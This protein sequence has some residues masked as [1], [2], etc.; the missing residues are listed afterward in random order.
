MIKQSK[1]YAKQCFWFTSLV[2]KSV[3]LKSIY[4]QLKDI[5]TEEVKTITMQQGNKTSRFVAWTFL[6]PAQQKQWVASRWNDHQKETK[7]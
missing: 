2:A 3:H 5:G 6:A 4:T 1:D 7:V